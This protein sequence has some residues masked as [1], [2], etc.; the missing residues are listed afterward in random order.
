MIVDRTVFEAETRALPWHADML[1]SLNSKIVYFFQFPP[2]KTPLMVRTCEKRFIDKVDSLHYDLWKNR[3][4]D[5]A[6][7]WLATYGDSLS[8]EESK[9]LGDIC[10]EIVAKSGVRG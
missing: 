2:G 1:G 5:K 10:Q 7:S 6:D 3:Q 4:I 9:D 8:R